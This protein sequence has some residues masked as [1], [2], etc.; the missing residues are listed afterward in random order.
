MKQTLD[1]G[2]LPGPAENIDRLGVLMFQTS[3]IETLNLAIFSTEKIPRI[4][5]RKM[6]KGGDLMQQFT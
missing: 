1:G 4:L 3:D 5:N 2:P 6:V